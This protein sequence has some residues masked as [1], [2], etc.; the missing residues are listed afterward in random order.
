MQKLGANIKPR[1]TPNPDFVMRPIEL[2]LKRKKPGMNLHPGLSSLH[3]T[4]RLRLLKQNLVVF[5]VFHRE[6]IPCP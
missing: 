2:H 1:P 3:S 4:Q 5:V 6:C